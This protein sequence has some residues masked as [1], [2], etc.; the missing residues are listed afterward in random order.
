MNTTTTRDFHTMGLE[1]MKE[2]VEKAGAGGEIDLVPLV[3]LAA[4][5]ETLRFLHSKGARLNTARDH[6]SPCALLDWAAGKNDLSLLAFLSDI[7]YSH[8]TRAWAVASIIDKDVRH[9]TVEA[10]IG[11][12]KIDVQF[13]G[14]FKE[15]HSHVKDCV[16]RLGSCKRTERGGWL[17]ILESLRNTVTFLVRN[18]SGFTTNHVQAAQEGDW[19]SVN[20]KWPWTK[21][22]TKD[23]TLFAAAER[24][25]LDII[26]YTMDRGAVVKDETVVA[27]VNSNPQAAGY[28]LSH[29]KVKHNTALVD[30]G[31]ECAIAKDCDKTLSFILDAVVGPNYEIRGHPLLTVAKSYY[32]PNCFKKLLTAGAQPYHSYPGQYRSDR[33][34]VPLEKQCRL[35]NDADFEFFERGQAEEINEK[36]KEKKY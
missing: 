6:D 22:Y 5:E 7:D 17:A 24:G 19:D 15:L 11:N 31:I 32:S 34:N 1:E 25:Y 18:K 26:K 4:D 23:E 28:M 3:F 14:L 21:Q 16:N 33:A 36:S 8:K 27:A 13:T 35:P 29:E 10:I 9:D 20:E 30:A 2:A 12:R